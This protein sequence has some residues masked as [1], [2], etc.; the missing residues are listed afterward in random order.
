VHFYLQLLIIFVAKN[1]ELNVHA[2][3]ELFHF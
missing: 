2:N 1:D 3:V